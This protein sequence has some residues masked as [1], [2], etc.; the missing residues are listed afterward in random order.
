MR[1]KINKARVTFTERSIRHNSAITAGYPEGIEPKSEEEARAAK[2]G[3]GHLISEKLG[4]I[5]TKKGQ[6]WKVKRQ[7]V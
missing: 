6:Y 5:T 7:G 4:M 1:I 3:E 2:A